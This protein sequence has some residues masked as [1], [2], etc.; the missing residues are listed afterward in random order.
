[1]S[2]RVFAGIDDDELAR[3]ARQ[4]E[5]AT[6][7]PWMSYVVG[8]DA[9]VETSRIELG[10]CNELGSFECIELI[11]G[12]AADHDFIASARQDVPRLVEEVRALRARLLALL[13]HTDD[14]ELQPPAGNGRSDSAMQS[15]RM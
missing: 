7:G 8:R 5:E 10:S 13:T 1:M 14:S 9:D 15:A 11:G 4:A 12:R 2:I 6:A 3:M